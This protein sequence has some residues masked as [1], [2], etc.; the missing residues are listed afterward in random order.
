LLAVRASR[1]L[2]DKHLW[3]VVGIQALVG[4]P[5]ST[6]RVVLG[7][8]R[9]G[10]LDLDKALAA[11][12]LV[13]AAGAIEVGGIRKET[14]GALRGVL[15]QVDLD[16]LTVDERIVRQHHLFRRQISG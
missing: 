1:W 4:I 2:R 13:A 5:R 6:V 7:Q 11:N 12:G 14:D 9:V 16:R 3:R 8:M 10:A 15:V